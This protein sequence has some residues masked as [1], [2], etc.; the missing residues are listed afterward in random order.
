MEMYLT[1]DKHVTTVRYLPVCTRC[2]YI[3]RD[4]I[5]FKEE[6]IETGLGLK[7]QK[8]IIVPSFCS[9]C[10]RYI[11]RVEWKDPMEE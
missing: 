4:D 10:G 6:I 2:G 9:E 8:H 1:S 7:Y 11:E 5:Q 3:F